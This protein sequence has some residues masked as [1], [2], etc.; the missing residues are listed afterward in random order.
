MKIAIL[1]P[2]SPEKLIKLTEAIHLQ[3]AD[4]EVVHVET[5]HNID[6]DAEVDYSIHANRLKI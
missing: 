2:C 1:G 6:L 5:E 4:V 3:N